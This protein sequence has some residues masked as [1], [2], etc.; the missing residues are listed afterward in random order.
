MADNRENT[1]NESPGDEDHDNGPSTD[2]GS[3][4]GGN[5]HDNG[6]PP[7]GGSGDGGNDHD[8]GPPPAGGSGDGGNDPGN[9]GDNGSQ[10]RFHIKCYLLI[11]FRMGLIKTNNKKPSR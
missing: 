8:N 10:G 9:G 11:M 2:G 6:P 3:G 7:A 5:D 1:E 4:D